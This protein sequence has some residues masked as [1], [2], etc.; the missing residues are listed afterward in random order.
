[1][2]CFRRQLIVWVP[3]AL[4]GLLLVAGASAQEAE[5]P[6][7]APP[8][9]AEAL[10]EAEVSLSPENIQQ[11][12]DMMAM[13]LRTLSERDVVRINNI[14][15]ELARLG[16]HA[17]DPL[18]DLLTDPVAMAREAAVIALTAMHPSRALPD[19]VARLGDEEPAVAMA[20]VVAVNSYPG[21]WPTKALVR[22]L[23]HPENVVGEAV[24]SALVARDAANIREIISA[25]YQT[26]PLVVGAG[27][28]LAAMGRFPSRNT[29][30][31]LIAGLDDDRVAIDAIRGLVFY[32]SKASSS[33]GRWVKKNAKGKPAIT[34]GCLAVLAGYGRA[35]DRVLSR[36]LPRLPYDLKEQAVDAL[37][38]EV[39]PSARPAVVGRFLA[40]RDAGLKRVALLRA[41]EVEGADPRVASD[42]N[43]RFRD[44]DVRLLTA[45]ALQ[46]VGRDRSVERLLITRYREVARLRDADNLEERALLLKGIG[47]A[48]TDEAVT[49]LVQATG[50]P[51]EV[52]A[53][54]NGLGLV[55]DRAISSLLFV[56]KTGDPVRTPMAV[57]ALANAG[58]N[59]LAPLMGL[60]IHPSLE[61]RN[62]AR[63]AVAQIQV[64]EVVPTIIEL[65]NDVSTPGRKQLI[66]LLGALYCEDSYTELKRLAQKEDDRHLREAAVGVLAQVADPRVFTILK[67]VATNDPNQEI[68]LMAVNGLIWQE[69]SDSVPFLIQLLDY[70]KDIIRKAV[71]QGLG[72]MA[73]PDDIA[74]IAPNLSTPRAEVITAVRNAMQR[75]SFQ[76]ELSIGDDFLEWREAHLEVPK[77]VKELRGG[78][79]TFADGTVMHYWLRG[80]GTPLLVLPDGPDYPHDYLRRPLDRLAANNLVIYVDLPGRGLSSGPRDPSVPMGVEHDVQSVATM[81][82]RLNLRDIYVY[83]HGYGAMVGVRL[84]D[85]HPKLVSRLV[86]DNSPRPTAAGLQ[87]RVNVAASRVPEPWSQD[88]EWFRDT[89]PSG[90][91]FSLEVHDRWLSLALLT[92]AVSN[93]GSLVDVWPRFKTR[94]SARRAVLGPMGD[95][96]LTE[97]YERIEVRTLMLYGAE[98]PVG[99]ADLAWR[100]GLADSVKK[101]KV[102]VIEGAGHLPAFEQPSEWFEA[103]DGFLP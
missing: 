85:K 56:I 87:S 78:Q 38:R 68:R 21:D 71:A 35:G 97:I 61:V 74:A 4:S 83:G 25:L 52:E 82:A 46:L 79:M 69:D 16:E 32:G 42:K 81:L 1:M 77:G 28:Y 3:A 91:R 44:R 57:R 18:L 102:K 29:L 6:A 100:S 53:A 24:L 63:Q 98:A 22:W 89:G 7:D 70:E 76:P 13:D 10:T 2:T 23:A 17:I 45:R 11:R 95:F 54:L 72:Y 80:E 34:A 27:P 66:S 5:A 50:Q 20:A 62:V 75:V 30:K 58:P 33:I 49:E 73:R 39:R 41:M 90:P 31:L 9:E 86:L 55:G 36:V 64:V 19:L 93:L 96:D 59:A 101:L 48:G 12:V 14:A 8:V 88:L 84:A 65:I 51:D 94:P 40:H 15:A 103:L 60:L 67:N 26:P 99:E 47:I 43:L 92:G 37:L